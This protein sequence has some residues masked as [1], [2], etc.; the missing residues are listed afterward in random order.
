[1]DKRFFVNSVFD[2][3]TRFMDILDERGHRR[4]KQKFAKTRKLSV[5]ALK[6]HM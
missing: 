6:I 5:K 4:T 2:K 3:K 1:M